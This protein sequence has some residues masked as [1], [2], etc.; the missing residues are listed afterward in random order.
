MHSEIRTSSRRWT[1]PLVVAVRSYSGRADRGTTVDER[2]QGQLDGLRAQV[3]ALDAELVAVLARRF[4][5]TRQ[6]GQLK[7]CAALP[8]LDASREQAQDERLCTLAAQQ[9][10]DAAMVVR[11]HEQIRAQVRAEHEAQAVQRS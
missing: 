8:A 6:I 5:V 11:I 7:A 2:T 3:D 1:I 4:A 9:G 10:L